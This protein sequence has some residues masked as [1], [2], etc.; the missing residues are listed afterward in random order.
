MMCPLLSSLH[1][2]LGMKCGGCVSHVKDLLEKHPDVIAATVNLA[3]ETALVKVRLGAGVKVEDLAEQLAQVGL[4]G[5]MGS[6]R[7]EIRR[8]CSSHCLS[9]C[10]SHCSSHCSCCSCCSCNS[11]SGT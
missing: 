5:E 9:H 6:H 10:L 8:P 11:S 4:E 1:Y 3:T 7:R 2:L